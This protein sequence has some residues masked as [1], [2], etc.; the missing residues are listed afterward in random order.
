M[1]NMSQ[2]LHGQIFRPHAS[3]P[4]EMILTTVKHTPASLR[5]VE[6]L[7]QSQ[8]VHKITDVR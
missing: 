6:M 2:N 8:S 3:I 1:T 5:N 7:V 4:I